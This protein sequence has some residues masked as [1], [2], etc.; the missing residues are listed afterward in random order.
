MVG[1]IESLIQ[2]YLAGK[3]LEGLNFAVEHGSSAERGHITANAAMVASKPLGQKP[4]VIAEEIAVYIRSKSLMEIEKVE[5]AGPGFLNIYLSRGY[6]AS[7]VKEI[8]NTPK[9]YGSNT[10]QK[11]KTMLYEYTDPNPFKEFHI[12]HLM[13][14]TVGEALSRIAQRQGAE[15]KRACYQGDVGPHI[16]KTIWAMMRN[17][18]QEG[19]TDIEYLGRAYSI[20]SQQ[21]EAQESIKKEIDDLN[22]SIYAKNNPDVVSL[23]DWGRKVSLEHFEEIYTKLGTK[24]DAYFFESEMAER[25]VKLVQ[26]WKEKGVFED[27][28][29]AVV[30]KG[31]KKG[32]HTRVFLNSRGLPTYEAKDLVLNLVD[33]PKKVP[34]D[35][36][37][38]ITANEQDDYFK[39]MLAAMEDI[40]MEARSKITHISHGMMRFKGGKMSSRKGNVVSG[41]GL[42]ESVAERVLEK[43]ADREMGEDA[44]KDLAEKIAI[45]SI[46]YSIL[47]QA[48]GGDIIFDPENAISIEGD[49]G[50]YLQYAYV[51]AQ[52][53]LRKAANESMKPKAIL[54]P[55]S[56]ESP[57][58]LLP[59]L[60]HVLKRAH[61]TGSPNLLVAY[62]L[63]LAGTFN[64]Y[65]AETKIIDHDSPYTPYRLAITY[66][67]A[68]VLREVLTVLA[69]PVVEEM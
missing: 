29:G 30:Y 31:E 43:M 18:K 59:E 38:I 10:E 24:F 17:E 20:G 7:T 26:E 40:D 15:V 14:N 69:I 3:G 61:E 22:V 50:P 56:P 2:E 44:K 47:R 66:A 60:P 63:K 34:S 33:K 16:A 23:Y 35:T 9:E 55:D 49:S 12:G 52:S 11:G 65:Y 8:L 21:Y 41:D 39:V 64:G 57:E 48:V 5:A 53:I 54:P 46:K 62:A 51:R 13:S 42:I 58:M 37:V 25:A 36:S 32:L 27:S 45:G 1:K 28:D 6:F 19:E 4:F 68:T 67:V